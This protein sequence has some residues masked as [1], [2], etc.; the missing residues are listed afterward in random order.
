MM[1]LVMELEPSQ[2]HWKEKREEKQK[3][4]D[5]LLQKAESL[6]NVQSQV[7]LKSVGK[8]L[9]WTHL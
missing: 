1:K 2:D 6:S 3:K 8:K 9:S 4:I 5:Y 7:L